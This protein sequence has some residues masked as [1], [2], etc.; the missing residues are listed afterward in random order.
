MTSLS[1]APMKV[2]ISYSHDSPEHQDRVLKLSNQLR[3]HGIDCYIDQYEI[4]P[5]GGWAKYAMDQV[6]GAR[7]ILLICTETYTRRLMGREELGMGRG[8]WFE[9]GIITNGFYQADG[10]KYIPVLFAKA[11]AEYIPIFLTTEPHYTLDPGKDYDLDA[12][13][14]YQALYRR[15]TNQPRH[16]RPDIGPVIVLPSDGKSGAGLSVLTKVPQLERQRDFFK[17]DNWFQR[18]V[19]VLKKNKII[20]IALGIAIL[21]ACLIV[22][23]TRL[24]PL[25]KPTAPDFSEKFSQ[26]DGARWN[27]LPSGWEMT[28]GKLHISGD[29]S[30]LL[31]SPQIGFLTEVFN[32]NVYLYDYRVKFHLKLINGQGAAWALRVQDSANYYLFYLS[33]AAPY[34]NQFL[35][36]IVRNNKC[37]LSHPISSLDISKL[38]NVGLI[39]DGSY[40]IYIKANGNVVEHMIQP[41]TLDS[42]DIGANGEYDL[43]KECKYLGKFI[44][45]SGKIFSYGSIGFGRIAMEDFSV[46]SLFVKPLENLPSP[47]RFPNEPPVKED[48]PK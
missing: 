41:L 32:S 30:Q 3:S 26:V 16:L 45:D 44:D 36:Y 2:F 12:D 33:G 18:L 23:F 38:I 21:S 6:Q 31:N 15:L 11:D 7:F 29:S 37:D 8:A 1:P 19:D 42:P 17:P 40:E 27:G 5:K 22:Y 43:S 25:P 20:A 4:A 28:E 24:T 9:G 48:P 39:V 35:T 34:K 14:G 46:S 13:E 47:C 10:G